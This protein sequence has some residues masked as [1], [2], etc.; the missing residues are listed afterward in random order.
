LL[1]FS[2]GIRAEEW[3]LQ[4]L[5]QLRAAVEKTHLSY[6]E[7]KRVALLRSPVTSAGVID[8][9]A[10]D[11]FRKQSLAPRRETM[12]LSGSQLKLFSANSSVHQIELDSIPPLSLFIGGLM[13]VLSGDADT[14]QDHFKVQLDG[15]ESDWKLDLVPR[16]QVRDAPEKILIEGNGPLLTRIEV[17]ESADNVSVLQLMTHE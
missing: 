10:P 16:Q 8:Y 5:M 7:E 13:A 15:P 1:L 3:N 2:C 11:Y 17:R 4:A 6:Q 14:L 9:R 12:E